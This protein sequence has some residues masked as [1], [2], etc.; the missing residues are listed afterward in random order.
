MSEATLLS[1]VYR[2]LNLIRTANLS[3]RAGLGC[4]LGIWVATRGAA[5]DCARGA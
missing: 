4:R 3:F 1:R 5:L 2:I